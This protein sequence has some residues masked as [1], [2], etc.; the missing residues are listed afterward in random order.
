MANLHSLDRK[1]NAFDPYDDL[2]KKGFIPDKKYDPKKYDEMKKILFGLPLSKTAKEML[3]LLFDDIGKSKNV[4]KTNK[5]VV[6]DLL[7]ELTSYVKFFGDRFD[8]V[9]LDQQL[10]EIKTGKCPA[11]RTIRLYSVIFALKTLI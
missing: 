8:L 10:S 1:L 2:K 7:V 3:N 4:D 11:G 6:D 9:T 5:L